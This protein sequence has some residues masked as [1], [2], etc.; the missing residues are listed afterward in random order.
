ME[1]LPQNDI[2]NNMNYSMFEQITHPGISLDL[3]SDNINQNLLKTKDNT[4]KQLKRK[5][6]AYEKNAE[7]QNQKLS[8]Y[9]HLLVEFNS[10]NKNYLQLKNDLEIIS[11]ENIQLKDI[12]NTKNQTILDFQSLFEASKSKFE[13]FNQTNTALKAK[14]VELEEKLKN[15]PNIL[16]NKEDLSQKMNDYETKIEQMK[17]EYNTKE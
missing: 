9:D 4:I 12:I 10:I 3:G 15:F 6:Q 16:K 8:D 5:I 17:E 1:E 7:A 11:N 13:L 14:I 2:I